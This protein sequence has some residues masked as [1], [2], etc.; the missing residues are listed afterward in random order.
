MKKTL[1]A[2]AILALAVSS[3]ACSRKADTEAATTAS[4]TVAETATEAAAEADSTAASEDAEAEEDYMSGLIT[5]IDGDILTVKND[6]DDTEKNYDISGAEVTQEF[7]FA[8]GDW[9]E[10]CYPAETTE[11]P[12]PVITLEVLDSVI[13]MNTDPS[14][15]GTVVD[16]TMNNITIEVDG[17]NYTLSTANAYIVGANGIQVDK[18]ATVTYVGELDDEAMAVK[19]VMEDS[20]GTPEAEINAFVGEVAQLSEEGESVVLESAEGDFYTFVSEDVD[21]SEYAE[22]DILQIEYTGTITA[23]EVPA[24]NVIKK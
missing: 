22:G 24:V 12:V 15:E 17:E 1:L 5:K 6:E 21:F 2:T 14:E 10:I 8:E 18:K 16:A 4:A 13:A 9:V 11:D 23:K 19:V 20:Y 7:P 3:A